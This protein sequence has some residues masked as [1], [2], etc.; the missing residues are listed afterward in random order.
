MWMRSRHKPRLA[1][2][3]PH[4]IDC[5]GQADDCPALCILGTADIRNRLAFEFDYQSV[6]SGGELGQ[7]LHC[8]QVFGDDEADATYRLRKLM[9]GF[10]VAALRLFAVRSPV[11]PSELVFLEHANRQLNAWRDGGQRGELVFS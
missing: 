7:R 9:S 1:V 4:V 6:F 10:G 2:G 3:L 5:R 11:T 8:R